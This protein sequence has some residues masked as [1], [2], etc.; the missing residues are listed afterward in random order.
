M[1]ETLSGAALEGGTLIAG[2]DGCKSGWL[3]V[4]LNDTG[5]IQAEI[6]P[7]A[8]AL[9]E[10]A[11]TLQVLAID[12]P[13][14]LACNGARAADTEARRLLGVRRSSV[15]PSPVR[16]AL[17]GAT[18]EEVCELSLGACGKRLSRQAYGILPKIREIDD[19][20]RADQKL[21]LII[22][23][24]HPEVCFFYLNGGQPMAESKKSDQGFAQRLHLIEAL[25]DGAFGKIRSQFERKDAQDDDIL[26]ALVALWTAG[27]IA[28]GNAEIL[29]REPQ[30]DQF[31]LRMQMLA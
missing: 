7:T 20:V 18:Y 10:R 8:Q 4:L 30:S 16:A 19:A 2:V 6:F 17:A 27:R 25:W 5:Q 14:S 28:A 31:G 26:D 23:E 9:M 1:Q 22:H 21:Q 12:V 15:F 13:I 29:P 24:V 11:L 3:C